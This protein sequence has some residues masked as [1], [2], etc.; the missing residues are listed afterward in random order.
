MNQKLKW[1]VV[2]VI[3]ISMVAASLY[4]TF[5]RSAPSL[6]YEGSYVEKHLWTQSSGVFEVPPRVNE[7]IYV[8][9]KYHLTNPLD[10]SIWFSGKMTHRS[11][12]I[13]GMTEFRIE[14]GSATSAAYAKPP[15]DRWMTGR[16]DCGLDGFGEIEV[17]PKSTINV[18]LPARTRFEGADVTAF[19]MP[20]TSENR[21][22]RVSRSGFSA[23]VHE[24]LRHFGESSIPVALRPPLERLPDEFDRVV[25]DRYPSPATMKP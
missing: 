11:K 1:I 3:G 12:L 10:H 19:R 14:R 15:G 21:S 8:W 16:G 4:L 18:L 22:S 17:P 23:I 7:M 13:E 6:S 9:D 25:D 20:Y 2:S 5:F 24:I